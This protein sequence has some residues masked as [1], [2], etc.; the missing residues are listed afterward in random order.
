MADNKKQAIQL[1]WVTTHDHDEDWFVFADSAK[2]AREFH[3]DYEGYEKGDARSRLIAANVDFEEFMN[4]TPPC[5]AQIPEL[6][7]LDFEIVDSDPNR[8]AV[9]L[10]GKVFVEGVLESLVEMARASLLAAE[11]NQA[12]HLVE[13]S[14]RPTGPDSGVP[15]SGIRRPSLKLVEG[16][17]G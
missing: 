7:H 16:R 3:E 1:Y 9:Q 5:H 13:V 2:S 10:N 11:K 14:S 15:P 6:L 12:I 8:R 4:G 17:R